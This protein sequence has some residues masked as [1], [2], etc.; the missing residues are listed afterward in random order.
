MCL[1]LMRCSVIIVKHTCKNSD[2]KVQFNTSMHSCVISV[3][4][5]YPCCGWHSVLRLGDAQD[6]GAVSANDRS[7]GSVLNVNKLPLIK[8]RDAYFLLSFL[9]CW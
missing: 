2:M 7:P 3:V 4:L 1:C 8:D 5:L 6:E 9:L